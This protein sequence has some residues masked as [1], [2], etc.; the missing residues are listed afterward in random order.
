MPR[1]HLLSLPFWPIAHNHFDRNQLPILYM[2]DFHSQPSLPNIYLLTM[3]IWTAANY[4]IHWIKLSILRL[5][6]HDYAPVVHDIQLCTVPVW[7]AT[8]A[9]IDW[10]ELPVFVHLFWMSLWTDTDIHTK[11][12]VLC[13][14]LCWSDK[15]HFSSWVPDVLVRCVSFW[16]DA[17]IHTEWDVFGVCLCIVYNR[18]ESLCC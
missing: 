2:R 4:D 13:L 14:R 9:D 16:P 18:F 5:R 3:P 15:H 1:K 11:W 12:D 17:Y 7:T 8:G 6:Q 10:R